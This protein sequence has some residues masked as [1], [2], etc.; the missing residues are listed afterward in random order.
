MTS[1]S[2]SL[3]LGAD[4]LG[5]GNGRMHAAVVSVSEGK[6][7]GVRRRFLSGFDLCR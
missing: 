5:S 7:R 3:Y 1:Q 2:V 4:L 6:D